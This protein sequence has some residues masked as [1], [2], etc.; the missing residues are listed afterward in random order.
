MQ[1]K[2]SVAKSRE[3]FGRM[4]KVCEAKAIALGV[5]SRDYLVGVAM[6]TYPKITEREMTD[7]E[8]NE[9]WTK[10]REDKRGP[11]GARGR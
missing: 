7:A 10:P 2:T 8:P 1:K 11:K 3:N 4:L 6:G 9:R 5:N